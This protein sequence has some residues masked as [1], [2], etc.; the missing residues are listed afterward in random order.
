MVL[1]ERRTAYPTDIA[2]G[3]YPWWLHTTKRSFDHNC[4]DDLSSLLLSTS[5]LDKRIIPVWASKEKRA[6]MPNVETRNRNA[7]KPGVK[8]KNRV[9]KD[10]FADSSFSENYKLVFNLRCTIWS[11]CRVSDADVIKAVA[12]KCWV[13]DGVPTGKFFE[14]NLNDDLKKLNTIGYPLIV[15]TSQEGTSKGITKNSRV[16]NL[17]QLQTEVEKI[18]KV[19]KQPALCEQFIKGTEFTVA[20]IGNE[21]LIALPVVQYAVSGNTNTAPRSARN[22]H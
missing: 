2:R 22:R 9:P 18:C 5:D 8:K 15:K 4:K 19:Y 20:V 12:K 11:P 13:A 16:E 10:L 14:A 7:V 17:Q 21:E 3:E 6:L 1:P